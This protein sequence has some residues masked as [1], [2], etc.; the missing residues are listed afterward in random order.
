MC[1]CVQE[2][3]KVAVC[4]CACL[5]GRFQG[6]LWEFL[7]PKWVKEGGGLIVGRDS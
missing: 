6:G 7:R 3:G 4:F 5:S 1:L 2:G